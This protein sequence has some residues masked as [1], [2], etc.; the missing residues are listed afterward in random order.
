MF[1]LLGATSGAQSHSYTVPSSAA[2][3]TANF[4]TQYQVTFAASP[5]AGGTTSPSTATWYNAGASAQLVSRQRTAATH[6]L[7]GAHR[8]QDQSLS[9]AQLQLQQQ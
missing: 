6:S 8:L 9:P 3:V 1:S 5:T 4:Q 2:T 7:H